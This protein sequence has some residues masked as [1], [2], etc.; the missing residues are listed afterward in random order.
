MCAHSTLT[1]KWSQ[2]LTPIFTKKLDISDA[3]IN[4]HI[5]FVNHLMESYSLNKTI[6]MS[7]Q[8]QLTTIY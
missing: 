5:K 2:E 7:N 4:T 6:R 8:K 1:Q 3:N